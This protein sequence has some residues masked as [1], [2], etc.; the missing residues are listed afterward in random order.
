MLTLSGNWTGTGLDCPGFCERGNETLQLKM[1][2]KKKEE[3][4]N[5]IGTFGITGSVSVL[6]S[7]LEVDLALKILGNR[8]VAKILEQRTLARLISNT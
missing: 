8:E 2:R 3:E 6:P 4:D 1:R 5:R 7:F